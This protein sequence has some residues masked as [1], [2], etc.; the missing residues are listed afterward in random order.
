MI[1]LLALQSPGGGQA[2]VSS[3][4]DFIFG[5]LVGLG[6]LGFAVSLAALL[7]NFKP[8]WLAWVGVIAGGLVVILE[9]V[10]LVLS[11]F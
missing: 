3:T 6:G 9:Y 7:S 1:F 5:L 10:F 8:R 11:D 4:A 2:E